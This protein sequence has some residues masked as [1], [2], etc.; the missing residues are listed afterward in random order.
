M[1]GQKDLLPEL[2]RFIA[3]P[4]TQAPLM[5][6][7]IEAIRR[8]GL[9]QDPRAGQDPTLPAPDLT[10]AQVRAALLR[11]PATLPGDLSARCTAL[12]NWANDRIAHG[13]PADQPYQ[14]GLMAVQPGDWLLMRNPSPY[15][16]FTD[17]SPGLFTH[18]GVVAWE[19]GAD[20]RGRMVLVD[21]PERGSKIDAT[22]VETFVK[23]SRHYLFLRHKDPAVAAKLGEA[24]AS[25]IGNP[26]KFDLNFRTD[27]VLELANQPLAGKTIH[28]YCAG[29]L[30]LCGLQTTEPRESFFP[31]VEYYRPGLCADNL[32]TLGLSFGKDFVS[33]TGALFSPSMKIIGRREPNYDPQHEV[34]EGIYEH[35]ATKLTQQPITVSPDLFQSLRM[36]VAAAAKQNTVLAEALAQAAGVGSDVDLLAAARAA[37]VVEILD[38]VAYGN[39]GQFS[40]A[41]DALKCG[42]IEL[43]ASQG[44]TPQAIDIV[45]QYRRLHAGLFQLWN[46]RQLTPRALRIELVKYYLAQGRRQIDQR[47]FT[48]VAATPAKTVTPGA[49]TPSTGTPGNLTPPNATPPDTAAA[50]P[51][52]SAA[53]P[54]VS[55]KVAPV[56]TAPTAPSPATPAP[57][58]AARQ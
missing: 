12:L 14:I 49:T 17:L 39:S 36:K 33:P 5:I 7:T 8:V 20:G 3:D 13:V 52:V 28:T 50:P 23:R 29:L 51:A 24:A 57:V 55:A 42:P 38:E 41:F 56:T 4:S 53:K 15:N 35:F 2:G 32:A 6:K 46:Q 45:Q 34:E 54:A 19:K 25:M 11:L 31:V 47:F 1:S 48:T 44:R 18:V 30:L 16:L 26:S 9:P 10:A 22:N 21:L 43:L 27:R 58:D 37:A 40:A